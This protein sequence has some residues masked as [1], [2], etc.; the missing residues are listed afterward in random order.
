MSR[1]WCVAS[2]QINGTRQFS[3]RS[4]VRN[5]SEKMNKIDL[6][7][8]EEVCE[9]VDLDPDH[10]IRSTYSGRGMYGGAC[11]GLV[12]DNVDELLMFVIELAVQGIIL[13][14]ARQDSMGLSTITYWPQFQVEGVS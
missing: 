1:L 3:S 7:T 4:V 14:G 2:D 11:L 5:E 8:L 10:A 13:D 12:H 9:N 6:Y